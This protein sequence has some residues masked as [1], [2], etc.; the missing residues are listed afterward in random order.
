MRIDAD[1]AV[2]VCAGPS[3]DRLSAQAWAKI[4]EAGA[5]V[6]VNGAAASLA[7]TRNNVRF[8]CLAAMDL[9]AGL[10]ENVPA[11]ISVWRNTTAWRVASTDSP[12][13]DAESYIVE[14]DEDDG[15]DGWSDD[16]RQGYKGGSTAMVIGNWLGN[17]WPDDDVTLRAVREVCEHT[18]KE[19]P[20]R[21]FR[22]LAYVG[23]DMHPGLGEHAHGAGNHISGFA[24]SAQ[25]YG[26][27][28]RGWE[29]FCGAAARRAIEVVNFTPG[30]A[31]DSMPRAE[32]PPSWVS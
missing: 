24:A 14:V 31:L 25:R 4:S 10:A 20:R 30:T 3:L 17:A 12:S 2:V 8:S 29:K 28:C 27:V 21:G 23:L 26:N 32:V 15:V 19:V 7:C 6:A 11:L 5:V 16:A 22:K 9:A 18:R 1:T 13:I